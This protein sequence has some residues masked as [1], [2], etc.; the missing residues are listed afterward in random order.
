MDALLMLLKVLV[1]GAAF[2]LWL[3]VLCECCTEE[4]PGKQKKITWAAVIFFGQIFGALL[5]CIFQR[6][7]RQSVGISLHT[8]TALNWASTAQQ[9]LLTN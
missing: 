6:P 2:V 9:H 8:R 4:P 5:Y 3:R 7:R 1:G